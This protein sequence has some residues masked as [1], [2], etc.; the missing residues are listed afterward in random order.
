I[1]AFPDASYTG[2]VLVATLSSD[3]T[4]VAMMTEPVLDTEAGSTY[5]FFEIST[6]G[7][8]T[9]SLYHFDRMLDDGEIDPISV[10]PSVLNDAYWIHRNSPPGTLPA[11][12]PLAHDGD[13][14]TLE[15]AGDTSTAIELRL[16]M[17]EPFIN[18]FYQ[19]TVSLGQG[20]GTTNVLTRRYPMLV[21]TTV[22][23]LTDA[24][25]GGSEDP[26]LWYNIFNASDD[27]VGNGSI[28]QM[29]DAGYGVTEWE[30]GDGYLSFTF[31]G[32]YSASQGHAV[33]CIGVEVTTDQKAVMDVSL[34]RL[35]LSPKAGDIV[36]VSANVGYGLKLYA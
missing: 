23:V 7:S 25:A 22:D 31:D 8:G 11:T 33:L 9:W 28:F 14:N 1:T 3:P 4:G 35:S 20:T 15:N 16:T 29:A 5:S 36:T 34:Q 26:L 12:E 32:S 19:V 24:G 27:V 18:S 10:V 13:V 2:G 21:A 30:A 17:A 6:T